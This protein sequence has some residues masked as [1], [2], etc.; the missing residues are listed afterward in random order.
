MAAFQ[1][2]NG[3]TIKGGYD[4]FGEPTPDARD[5]TL[6]ETILSGDIG[7]LSDKSDNCYHVFYHPEGLNL[8]DTAILD[9][10]MITGGNA[11]GVSWPQTSGGGMFNQR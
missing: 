11:N 6:Y 3:V 8:D 7:K 5:I 2:I 9:G 1:L 4:G 10:F